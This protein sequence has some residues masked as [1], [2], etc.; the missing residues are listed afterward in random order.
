MVI[1]ILIALQVDNWNTVK[2]EEK[3]LN[4]YLL[5]ISQNI[6][7][8]LPVIE[9]LKNQRDTMKLNVREYW[10]LSNREFYEIKDA[11][12]LSSTVIR[13]FEV[14]NFNSNQS[15]FES[16]KTSGLIGKI[17]GTQMAE[18]LFEYY[19]KVGIINNLAD[20]ANTFTQSMQTELMKQEITPEWGRINGRI[21]AHYEGRQ[22]MDEV[23]W[24]ESQGLLKKIY[25]HPAVF[26]LMARHGSNSELLESYQEIHLLGSGIVKDIEKYLNI[27]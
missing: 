2:S 21:G 1:G 18:S 17:Q 23:F 16:L 6:K 25:R 4:E 20:R 7:S 22:T 11:S 10:S 5:T 9:E 24:K 14:R 27:N 13:A 26:A 8:D 3:E 15:G 19:R 12:K